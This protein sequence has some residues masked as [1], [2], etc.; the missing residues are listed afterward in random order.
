MDSDHVQMPGP[1]SGTHMRPAALRVAPC[2]S[3]GPIT[4]SDRRAERASADRPALRL[5]ESGSPI[6]IAGADTPR[7]AALLADLTE[8][9]PA[10]T[11][12]EELGTLA[13]VLERAP[14]SRMV[15]LN[16]GLEDVSGSALMRIL[17][18][19]HP[20]LPVISLELP[21]PDDL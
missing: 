15:I 10:G 5:V 6:L 18:Q 13:E 9:L 8:T 2:D 21:N 16:G 12:F 14:A 20:T 3:D 11:I 17:G 4:L 19:R 7:R 1:T